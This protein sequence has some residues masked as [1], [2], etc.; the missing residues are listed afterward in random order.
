MQDLCRFDAAR[1]HLADGYDIQVC[2]EFMDNKAIRCCEAFLKEMMPYSDRGYYVIVSIEGDNEAILEDQG[3]IVGDLCTANGA[4]EATLCTRTACATGSADLARAIQIHPDNNSIA[5]NALGRWK[6]AI[7]DT[8]G[9]F[10]DI[11][12]SIQLDPQCANAYNNRGAINLLRHNFAAAAADFQEA[13]RLNPGLSDAR[14][15][16][17][18]AIAHLGKTAGSRQ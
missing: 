16:L 6:V 12:R 3:V 14:G 15:N 17:K 1:P 4:L 10:A 8:V 13:I 18:I 7:G 9:A 2:V 5:Y 11:N